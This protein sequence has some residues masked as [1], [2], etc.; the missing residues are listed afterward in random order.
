MCGIA[1][2]TSKNRI[3]NDDLGEL[4][5]NQKDRGT[6]GFGIVKIRDNRTFSIQRSEIEPI[7]VHHLLHVDAKTILVHH[8]T[9]TSSDNE[10]EQTHPMVINHKSLEHTYIIVHNGVIYNK[11]ECLTKFEEEGYVFKTKTEDN[12][13]NDSEAFA[14]DL[15]MMLEGKHKDWTARGSIAFIALRVEKKTQK[16]DKVMFGVNGNPLNFLVTKYKKKITNLT[17]ASEGPGYE[18]EDDILLSYNMK[19]NK[20]SHKKFVIGAKYVPIKT[21]S[22]AFITGSNDNKHNTYEDD[23]DY[24]REYV[25]W[26]NE[27][28]HSTPIE[29][30]YTGT[31]PCGK[32]NSDSSKII[33]EN[34]TDAQINY[35]AEKEDAIYDE[36][37][38]V[39]KDDRLFPMEAIIESMVSD[40]A[41]IDYEEAF[42]MKRYM[43]RIAN[44]IKGLKATTEKLHIQYDKLAKDMDDGEEEITF[45][46]DE[47]LKS[48]FEEDIDLKDEKHDKTSIKA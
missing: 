34:L 4:Y 45:E 38:E 39:V 22:S 2:K 8:R 21:T 25:K 18:V 32:G 42:N 27:E 24:G 35:I 31:K 30:Y 3:V 11:E 48:N 47:V 16:V 7:F 14:F 23:Y 19:T 13:F 36:L 10:R 15:A 44:A 9:P 26:R 41:R 12:K 40:L 43:A 6:K 5:E 1:F 33:P 37:S 29:G 46:E 28:K 20:L 17:I